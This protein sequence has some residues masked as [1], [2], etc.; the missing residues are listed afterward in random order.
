M[1]AGGQNV[2]VFDALSGIKTWDE[3]L[4]MMPS[5]EKEFGIPPHNLYYF[6]SSFM[7][8]SSFTFLQ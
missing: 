7:I 1:W 3:T 8:M 4:A 6:I 5:W 2:Q